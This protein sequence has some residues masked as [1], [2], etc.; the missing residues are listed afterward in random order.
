ME[1]EIFYFYPLGVSYDSIENLDTII[2]Y[3]LASLNFKRF[4][5]LEE[6]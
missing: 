2:L 1:S 6:Y 4:I 3:C 5:S